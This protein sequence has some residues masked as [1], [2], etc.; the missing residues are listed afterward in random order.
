MTDSTA[1]LPRRF[2]EQYQVEVVSLL[3]NFESVSFPEEEIYGD[4]DPFYARLSRASSLPTTSQ[5]SI[6]DFLQ[7]YER[8]GGSVDSIISIHITEGISGTVKSAQAAARMLPG[9]DITVIDSRKTS[10]GLYMVVEA[11]AQAVAAGLEKEEV[12]AI[13]CY[14]VEHSLVLFTLD[15]LEYLRRGGRIGGAASLIGNL[16]Q[17][18]PILFF[19][20]G[21]NNIIDLYDKVR[22]REKALRRILEEMQKTAPISSSMLPM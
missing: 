11:A 13:I 1:Y 17:I 5:P 10:I 6:G 12:L 18:K 3:V 15:T 19:N 2:R 22:T 4:Y 7:A 21:K 8:L 9:L 16:L 20:P 14:V